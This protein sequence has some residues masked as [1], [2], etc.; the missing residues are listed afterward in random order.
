MTLLHNQTDNIGSVVVKIKL[1]RKGTNFISQLLS[2]IHM[3][4]H[5]KHTYIRYSNHDGVGV[6]SSE[7]RGGAVRK[8]ILGSF[9]VLES[10]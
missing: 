3:Q 8:V 9:E 6:D 10:I 1:L 4:F 2:Y 5:S 7:R